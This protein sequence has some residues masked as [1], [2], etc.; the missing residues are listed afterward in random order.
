MLVTSSQQDCDSTAKGDQ[1]SHGLATVSAQATGRTGLSSARWRGASCWVR[2]GRCTGT[3]VDETGDGA[4][5]T[6][7]KR[8]RDENE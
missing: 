1:G 6:A 4:L 5:D 3:S 7:F 8:G 2:G